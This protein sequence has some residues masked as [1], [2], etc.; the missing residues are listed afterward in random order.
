MNEQVTTSSTQDL[1]QQLSVRFPMKIGEWLPGYE[2]P[3]ALQ[4]K[5][6]TW[7]ISHSNQVDP[8]SEWS[9]GGSGKTQSGPEMLREY[10]NVAWIPLDV[11]S[12]S[13]PQPAPPPGDAAVAAI[14]FAL[15]TD[16]GLTFLRLWNEGEFDVLRREWPEAPEDIYIGAD[17]LHPKSKAQAAVTGSFINVGTLSVFEDKEA[18]FGF[19]YDISANYAGH[20]L[21]QTLDGVQLFAM[22]VDPAPDSA[23]DSTK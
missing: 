4:H 15:K 2:G 5:N 9:A 19:A 11:A 6:G 20:K 16:D 17:A 14:A 13:E 22:K 7:S 8:S 23:Q 1:P 3:S 21:L 12:F 18:S 10:G